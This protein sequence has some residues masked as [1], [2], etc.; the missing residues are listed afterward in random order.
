M[1]GGVAGGVAG[2]F[3]AGGPDEPDGG[4]LELLQASI[5]A[6]NAAAMAELRRTTDDIF[7][8]RKLAQ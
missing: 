3:P 7:T 2:G 5:N 6:Q 1:A 8:P 4:L